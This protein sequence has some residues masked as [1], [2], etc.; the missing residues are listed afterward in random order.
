MTPR[1][2]FDQQRKNSKH[3]KIG[4][5][6]TFDQWLAIWM[7]SGRM[8]LRGRGIGRFCM[9]RIGD[10]G[11]YAVGNVEIKSYEQ[12]VSEGSKG[13][14]RTAEQNTARSR[15]MKGNKHCVGRV[16]YGRKPDVA[17]AVIAPR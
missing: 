9:S 7:A 17:D 2:A 3:R 8:G 6:L 11:P 10:R 1:D 16:N 5:E 4:W 15:W 13:I 12:N 14:K